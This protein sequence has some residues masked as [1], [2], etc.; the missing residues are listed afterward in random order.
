MVRVLVVDDDGNMRSMVSDV[1]NE[2]GCETVSATNGVD[3]LY[4]LER[5]AAFDVVLTDLHMPQMDGL[6]LLEQLAD[7]YPQIPII[8]MSAHSDY[9]RHFFMDE[10]AVIHLQKPFT[11]SELVDTVREAVENSGRDS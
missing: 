3:A 11:M 7:L 6:A 9:M 2:M 4:I 1:L 10:G 8:L 5:D